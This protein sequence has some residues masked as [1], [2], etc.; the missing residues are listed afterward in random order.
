MTHT[1]APTSGNRR[2]LPRLL[3]AAPLAVA[4]AATPLAA[5]PAQA[6]TTPT[7]CLLQY[8]STPN[9]T[10]YRCAVNTSTGKI[11]WGGIATTSPHA[12]DEMWLVRNVP[13]GQQ[14]VDA[15]AFTGVWA[16]FQFSA[17]WIAEHPSSRPTSPDSPTK[18]TFDAAPGSPNVPGVP[19]APAPKPTPP[20]TIV[21]GTTPSPKPT[22]TPG[23]ATRPVVVMSSG[24]RSI[25]VAVR[26]T[27]PV[28]MTIQRWTG[29]AWVYA[30][31]VAVPATGT[32][33]KTV[34]IPRLAKNATYRV[35]TFG[36]GVVTTTSGKIVS[37]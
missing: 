7:F 30:G 31:R 37:R 22:V 25:Q 33:T 36:P 29:T 35:I 11:T 20:V 19:G 4:L 24:I 3:A 10:Q 5:T 12:G 15:F 17:Q 21:V 27:K 32:K 2:R 26:T 14:A 28:T 6:A 9:W 34:T 16:P 1:P 18:P 23:P 8:G 13:G